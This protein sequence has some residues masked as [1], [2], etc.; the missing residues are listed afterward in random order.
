[1]IPH[2]GHSFDRMDFANPTFQQLARHWFDPFV[3][4]PVLCRSRAL[5]L[6]FDFA[7]GRLRGLLVDRLQRVVTRDRRCPS[8]LTPVMS[9]ENIIFGDDGPERVIKVSSLEILS[10]VAFVKP[11]GLF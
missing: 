3:L 7:S 5:A 10:C 11:L 2:G 9:K 6:G 1:V 8:S 4:T